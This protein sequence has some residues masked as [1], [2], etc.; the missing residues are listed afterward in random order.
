[1]LK[2]HVLKIYVGMESIVQHPLSSEKV[3]GVAIFKSLGI[4]EGHFLVHLWN[5]VTWFG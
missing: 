1:M 3:V 2:I 5:Q 4:V